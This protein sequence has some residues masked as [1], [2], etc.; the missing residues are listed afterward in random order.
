MATS[1]S[2][3]TAADSRISAGTSWSFVDVLRPTIAPPSMR[4]SVR[5]ATREAERGVWRLSPAL[6]PGVGCVEVVKGR[7]VAGEWDS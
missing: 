5:P 3:L 7:V 1:P 6:W 2:W 4:C